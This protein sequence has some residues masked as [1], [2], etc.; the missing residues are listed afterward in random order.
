M[1][2]KADITQRQPFKRAFARS[3]R[4]NPTEAERKLWAHLRAGRLGNLRFRRQQPIGPYIVDFFCPSAQLVVELDGG[5]HGMDAAVAYDDVRSRFLESRGY[6]VLR[7]W[8]GEV[9]KD[10]DVVLD[11]IWR[12]SR[13]AV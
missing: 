4:A 5:Q 12:A 2:R 10:L 6:Q 13:P 7:F 3:L 1:A 9:L 8:N 11:T